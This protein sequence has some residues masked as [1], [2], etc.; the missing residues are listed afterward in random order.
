MTNR[1]IC[2]NVLLI[3]TLVFAMAGTANAFQDAAEI[4]ASIPQVQE[5]DS[6]SASAETESDSQYQE[7]EPGNADIAAQLR[8][9]KEEFAKQSIEIPKTWKRLGKN[10]IWADVENKRAIVRGA[11]CLEQGLL[12]MFA[13]PRQTK[14][15]EAVV[16]VHAP[17]SQ[18]HAT[19]L[20]VGHEPGQPMLW[21][22]KYYPATG[23]LMQVE[24]WWTDKDG[25]LVK[26]RA[27]EMIRNTKTGKAMACDFVFAGS[28]KVYDPYEKKDI[29]MAD[30]GPMINVANQ[31]DAM[32][33]VAIESSAEAQGSLFEVFTENVPPVNTK[34]Y[35]VISATGKV[36]EAQERPKVKTL[37]EELEEAKK[38]PESP[39]EAKDE[40][41]PEQGSSK[42]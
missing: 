16:S 42:K 7:Y 38:D 3:T 34:V 14:E 6:G 39:T 35:I 41:Q 33:D 19:L 27:Q 5:I 26:R 17:A 24:L 8:A 2:Q 21:L 9:E 29:Y 18:V 20:A 28:E 25:K 10:H 31:P 36:I 15:H 32:I 37:A 30:Y 11:T 23:P 4:P 40:A 22:E 1:I 13:C 12:E